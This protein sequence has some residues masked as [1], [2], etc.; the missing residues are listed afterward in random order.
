MWKGLIISGLALMA[1]GCSNS[2]IVASPNKFQPSHLGAPPA[3]AAPLIDIE[4]ELATNPTLGGKVLTAIALERVTGRKPHPAS[5]SL[6]R[7]AGM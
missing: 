2:A 5:L 4:A 7:E 1:A 6:K 3:N